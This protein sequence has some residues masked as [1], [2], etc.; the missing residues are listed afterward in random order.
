MKT[1]LL[2]TIALILGIQ[3]FNDAQS[4]SA[5]ADP[6][7]PYVEVIVTQ[8][9][10]W[11]IPDEMP[12]GN[13]PVQIFN[14]DGETVLQK[15]F[16]SELKDWSMDVTDLPAGKYKIRIGSIQTEYLEKQGRKRVL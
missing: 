13:L 8:E 12:V 11:L 2:L 9:K 10:I 1:K 4:A 16:C 15:I 14:A 6:R 3:S 7:Y 5:S